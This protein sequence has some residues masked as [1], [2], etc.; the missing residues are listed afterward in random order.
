MKQVNEM[1]TEGKFVAV[2][3]NDNGVWSGVFIFEDG[4]LYEYNGS[5]DSWDSYHT[6]Y[7]KEG[8][9]YSTTYFVKI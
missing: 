5:E 6:P 3:E 9:N 2:W 1:P 8:G 4:I 7:F